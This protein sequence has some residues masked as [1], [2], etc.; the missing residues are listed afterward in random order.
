MHGKHQ[1]SK[2]VA[3]VLDLSAA[4][5]A[6]CSERTCRAALGWGGGKQS[7]AWSKVKCLQVAE[8]QERSDCTRPRRA[9]S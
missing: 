9:S 7:S 3:F 4:G 8:L 5:G 1:L 6:V 2:A